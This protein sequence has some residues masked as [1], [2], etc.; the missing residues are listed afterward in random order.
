[1]IVAVGG[2]ADEARC[3]AL[4]A[5]G[6]EVLVCEGA[7]HAQRFGALLDELGRRHFTN[8]LVEGGS[9]LLGSLLDAR[10]IDEV[11]VFI[12]PKLIGGAGAV[13]AFAGLGANHIAEAPRLNPLRV[14][15]TNGD[16]YIQAR[17]TE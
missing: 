10:E 2:Q 3:R 8:V 1:V 16:L 4:R 6:C 12:A 17:L 5:A 15:Q 7:S 13:P 9:R 11:H 14:E